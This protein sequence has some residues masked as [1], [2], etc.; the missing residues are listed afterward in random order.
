[1]TRATR[2]T[3]IA[4][5]V[6]VMIWLT[7]T[8]PMGSVIPAADSSQPPTKAPM[9]PT[10]RCR[11]SPP[12][13]RIKLASQPATSP[14]ERKMRSAV[15][16]TGTGMFS[17]GIRLVLFTLA[18]TRALLNVYRPPIGVEHAVLHGFA[19]GRVREDRVDQVFLGGFEAHGNNEALDQLRD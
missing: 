15:R 6:A 10:M 2:I 9:T 12:P 4:P 18:A 7:S 8:L 13:P 11:T 5:I 16:S 14:M 17:G 3:I 1:M 19:E